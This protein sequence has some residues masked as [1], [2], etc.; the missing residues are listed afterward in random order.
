MCPDEFNRYKKTTFKQ[1]KTSLIWLLML[2]NLIQ[3]SIKIRL[4][5]LLF[6]IKR[7]ENLIKCLTQLISVRI[8][9]IKLF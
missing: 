2:S 7:V 9:L 1:F 4:F 5:L 3:Q 6:C 8:C